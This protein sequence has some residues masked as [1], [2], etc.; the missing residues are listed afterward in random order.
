MAD[1]KF[2][3]VKLTLDGKQVEMSL[4][5]IRK[6]S[7]QTASSFTDSVTSMIIITDTCCPTLHMLSCS[8]LINITTE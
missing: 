4:D 7:E 6:K 1:L 8:S 5:Q 2:S 3:K